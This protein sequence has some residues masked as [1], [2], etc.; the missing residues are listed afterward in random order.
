MDLKLCI[1]PSFDEFTSYYL[2]FLGGWFKNDIYKLSQATGL[3]TN[4]VIQ[5]EKYFDL[6][7]KEHILRFNKYSTIGKFIFNDCFL[8]TIKEAKILTE[9]NLIKH[10]DYWMDSLELNQ[11]NLNFIL[12]YYPETHGETFN[13][14][15]SYNLQ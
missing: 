6:L 2:I 10:I 13:I 1:L 15:R 7:Y 3:S 4:K 14:L 8:I 11:I 5:C 12:K 9:Y